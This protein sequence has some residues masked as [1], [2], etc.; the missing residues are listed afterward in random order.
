MFFLFKKKLFFK[1]IDFFLRKY[2][3]QKFKGKKMKKI[4][5]LVLLS[6]LGFLLS[7]NN[8]NVYVTEYVGARSHF[9]TIQTNHWVYDNAI[10][11]HFVE[12]NYPSI[13]RDVI[14]RG[15]VLVYMADRNST[16][17]TW[18][19][20]PRTEVYF[21]KE[22]EQIDY[23]IEWGYWIEPNRLEIEYIR[24]NKFN[25]GPDTKIDIKVV[26]I[27][28]MVNS[29]DAVN[30]DINFENYDEVIKHFKVK[31]S[32]LDIKLNTK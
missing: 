1:T 2:R 16:R 23:T 18:T 20:M 24:S 32:D 6:A 10:P 30:D 25:I 4:I 28:D 7:C 8:E 9:I 12:Y 22:T 19:L 31:E 13:T 17:N 3:K 11:K 5:S 27:D 29:F 14:D 15:L 21:N 26:I